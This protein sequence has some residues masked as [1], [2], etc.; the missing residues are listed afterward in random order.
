MQ[1]YEW[2]EFDKRINANI[3]PYVSVINYSKITDDISIEIG[4]ITN[5][6]YPDTNLNPED[7]KNVSLMRWII[8]NIA[9]MSSLV[10]IDQ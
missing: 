5:M 10:F 9:E 4:H 2:H 7:N 6:F 3:I 1:E 8:W